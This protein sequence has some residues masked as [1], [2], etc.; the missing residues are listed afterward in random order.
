MHTS[1]EVGLIAGRCL[2]LRVNS[3]E[4]TDSTDTD[5]EEVEEGRPLEARGSAS[6]GLASHRERESL[7]AG[8]E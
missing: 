7:K 3:T 5:E 8:N 2:F 6:P 4:E 1:S